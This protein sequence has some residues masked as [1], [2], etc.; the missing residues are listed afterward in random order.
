MHLPWWVLVLLPLGVWIF[1]VAD[2]LLDA[3]TGMQPFAK[4]KLHE[5]HMFHWRHRRILA[6]FALA[7]AVVAAWIIFRLM[8]RTTREH[9]SLLAAA[10]LLYFTQVHSGR[11]FLSVPSKELLVGVIFTFG[12][13]LPALS[14]AHLS[15]AW[16]PLLVTTLFFAL[17]AWLNCVAI[18]RWESHDANS[19]RRS[20]A[21]P[22]LLLTTA[23]LIGSALLSAS[24]P[25]SAG[26]LA[27]AAAAA[28]VLA[29]LDRVRGR[30]TPITLRVAADLA[31][32]TPAILFGLAP[33]LRP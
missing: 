12:C 28:L 9:D 25:R 1:Y 8:P 32:L 18:D 11:R 10:S 30:L 27:C 3:R 6:P 23:C 7:S 33:I 29:A 14:R 17:L 26:L 13:A 15:L 24:H 20:I 21:L 31:L 2:R 19:S 16:W 5:R 22:A 4:A